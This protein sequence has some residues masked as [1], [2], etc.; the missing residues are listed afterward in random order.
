MT[1]QEK[2]MK[3]CD[4]VQ[5]SGPSL[6]IWTTRPNEIVHETDP[7]VTGLSENRSNRKNIDKLSIGAE[8]KEKKRKMSKS[9]MREKRKI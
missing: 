8:Q 1:G 5:I 3:S 2:F 9:E 4:W 6:Y 7:V